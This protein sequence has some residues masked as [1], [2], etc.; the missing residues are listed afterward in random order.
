MWGMEAKFMFV[1]ALY[2][3]YKWVTP[4]NVS[5][6]NAGCCVTIDTI[7]SVLPDSLQ[8]LP[9]YTNDTP[10]EDSVRLRLIPN[11][12]IVEIFTHVVLAPS[13]TAFNS[14]YWKKHMAVVP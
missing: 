5:K 9:A 14:K 12:F 13:K 7:F 4:V 1:A 6:M 8:N 10:V 2:Y 3:H 11:F